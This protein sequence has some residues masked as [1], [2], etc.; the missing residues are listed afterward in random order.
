VS[1][2]ASTSEKGPNRRLEPG[3]RLNRHQ[4]KYQ[5]ERRKEERR[6]TEKT[7]EAPRQLA[8]IHF[9]RAKPKTPN[10]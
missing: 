2:P 4:E 10:F 6:K 5:E 3:G 1:R 9:A 8:E 7:N